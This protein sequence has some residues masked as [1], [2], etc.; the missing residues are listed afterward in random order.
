MKKLRDKIWP[1][2]IEDKRDLTSAD[3]AAKLASYDVTWRKFVDAHECFMEIVE[4]EPEKRRAQVMYDEELAKKMELGGVV[5]RFRRLPGSESMFSLRSV[6]Q[7]EIEAERK[8]AKTAEMEAE[9]AYI[10]FSAL[11]QENGAGKVE[12]TS[13]IVKKEKEPPALKLV[14]HEENVIEQSDVKLEMKSPKQ[15]NSPEPASYESILELPIAKRSKQPVAH[16]QEDIIAVSETERD[17]DLPLSTQNIQRQE[18][19]VVPTKPSSAGYKAVL[20]I[21][22]LCYTPTPMNEWKERVLQT[23]VSMVLLRTQEMVISRIIPLQ[24]NQLSGTERLNQ[25][26]Q[27][28]S[29]SSMTAA[30]GAD[31]R[32]VCLGVLPVQVKAK[33]G[34]RIME[35]YAL[36]ESG[37][38]VTL[39]KEQL[40]SELGTRGSKC[41]YEL[42]GVT[43]LRKIEGHVVDVVVMSVDGKVSEELLN[44]RTVEQ[45]PVAVSCIPRKEDISNWFHLRDIDLQQL[46]QSDVGL[47]IGLKEK[48]TLFIP[49]ECRSGKSG[50]PVA[51]LYSLG[52]TVMGP[53]SD[54]GDSNDCS[55]NFLRLGK[56]E[57]YIDEPVEEFEVHRLHGREGVDRQRVMNEA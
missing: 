44:V 16:P 2:L 54:V 25:E 10:S 27:S 19:T 40:F 8:S 32:R 43:G 56:R 50:E 49:L 34:A 18:R 14:G 57:F 9:R 7:L 13:S 3:L 31:E 21:T 11:D 1:S 20:K 42:Q 33:G 51:V 52:W 38:E 45:I 36:L 4:L 6:R 22:I 29:G 48:P 30:T 24:V 35:T 28:A 23:L 37:S 41:S 26:Q 5:K 53:L 46:S 55:V 17:C 15:D 39:C 12:G 47:I